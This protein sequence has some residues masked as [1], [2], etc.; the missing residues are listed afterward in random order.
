MA[1]LTA[2][3]VA[4]WVLK[5][6][7]PPEALLPGWGAGEERLLTRCL[8]PSYRLGL[9]AP[10]R[11]CLLWL[12]GRQRPGVHAVGTLADHVDDAPGGPSVAVRVRLLDEPVPRAELLTDPAFAGAEVV[13]MPAGSNPS[14]LSAGQYAAVLARAGR[15]RLGSWRA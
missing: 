2:D 10:G 12:S 5:T 3:D 8:R 9:L 1:R 4:C 15:N 11:P 6:A 13:R 7:A 14:W